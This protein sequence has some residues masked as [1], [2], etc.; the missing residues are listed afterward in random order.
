MLADIMSKPDLAEA[1]FLVAV[2]VFAAGLLI[3]L[4][5]T[6]PLKAYD[7]VIEYTGLAIL[8]FG[9]LAL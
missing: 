7:R 5:K 6:S 4:S 9:F 3:S 1:C 8:A 2:I